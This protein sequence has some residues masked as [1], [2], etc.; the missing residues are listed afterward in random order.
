MEED[1]F[2]IVSHFFLNILIERSITQFFFF[3]FFFEIELMEKCY[4]TY[5]NS[6][7]ETRRR[8]TH[9]NKLFEQEG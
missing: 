3:F 9:E 5:K 6:V 1:I 8:L 4:L 7:S 2:L